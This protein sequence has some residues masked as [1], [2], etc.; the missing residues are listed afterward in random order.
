M[1]FEMGANG[2]A[3]KLDFDALGVEDA[4][5]SLQRAATAR[6]GATAGR[7]EGGALMPQRHLAVVDECMCG[8][9]EGALQI[10]I[11][12]VAFRVIPISREGAMESQLA[13]EDKKRR[14]LGATRKVRQRRRK[15]N[16]G[17]KRQK[18]EKLSTSLSLSL[19]RFPRLNPSPPSSLSTS[20]PSS[21]QFL[22]NSRFNKI[23]TIVLISQRK[24]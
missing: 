11:R 14:L 9:F 21:F 19:S 15:T 5:L 22:F 20:V 18:N 1:G 3:A 23:V 2:R 10:V 4:V 24:K 12:A 13:P 6:R 8:K 17:R 7:R 16:G